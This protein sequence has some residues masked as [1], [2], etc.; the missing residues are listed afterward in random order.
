MQVR[1]AAAL[2]ARGTRRNTGLRTRVA[3]L[4]PTP[5]RCSTLYSRRTIA[6][7]T[8]LDVLGL[9]GGPTDE[10]ARYVVAALLNV[11]A[12]LVPVLTATIVKDMWSE[13]L[14]KGSF[15]PSSGAT[16]TQAE[17][18]EYLRITSPS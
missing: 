17:L 13:Y 12:A 15:S 2:P 10:V 16:W 3:G 14:A 9:N 18:V 11:Q 4:T 7:K 6:G 1:Q 8:L 5:P